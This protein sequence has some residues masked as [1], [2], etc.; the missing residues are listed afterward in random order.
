M[1]GS[2]GDFSYVEAKQ[3]ALEKI[4]DCERCL[5]YL[6]SYD[7]MC[8]VG[9]KD[10][11]IISISKKTG[12]IRCFLAG[13][14]YVIKNDL[15]LPEI[16]MLINEIEIRNEGDL[17]TQKQYTY[18]PKFKAVGDY[19]SCLYDSAKG[20]VFDSDASYMLDDPDKYQISPREAYNTITSK[21][22]SFSFW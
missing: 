21:E 22:Y 11:K 14:R 1:T 2:F 4:P 15:S 19:K 10:S 3:I 7:F 17:F 20:W 6:H 8:A 16:D 18:Y 12:D 5:E 9:T 13:N